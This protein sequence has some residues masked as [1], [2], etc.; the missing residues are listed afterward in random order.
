MKTCLAAALAIVTLAGSASAQMLEDFEHGDVTLWAQQTAGANLFLNSAAAYAGNFGG[1]F[2]GSGSSGWRTRFDLTTEPG[3]RYAA[4]V[5]ARNAVP[6]SATRSYLGVGAT[7]AGTWSAV[8][9][10]N[11]NQILLQENASYGFTTRA[12]TSIAWTPNTWYVLVLDWQIDGNMIVEL[13]DE[14][15]TTMI[16]ATAPYPTGLV[17]AGGLAV[18]GFSSTAGTAHDID[19]IRALGGGSVCYANCDGSSTEPILNVDDFTCFINEFAAAQGLPHEQQ[20]TSYANCDG[21]TIAPALNVDDFTC[22]IN[23][24][25]QGCP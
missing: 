17:T 5:R 21:S 1:E 22:F 11:T 15:M 25:A 16:A 2:S 14:G 23:S 20:V 7:A 10:P 4:N 13:W 9:G 6:G 12:A 3:K 24:F 19:E 8:F 18:R